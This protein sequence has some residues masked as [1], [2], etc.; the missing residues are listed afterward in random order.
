MNTE[1]KRMNKPPAFV[2]AKKSKTHLLDVM[3]SPQ[4]NEA[5][6]DDRPTLED[7]DLT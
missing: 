2:R 1:L 7:E 5:D 6:H 3:S 4:D